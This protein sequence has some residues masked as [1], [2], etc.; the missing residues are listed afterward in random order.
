MYY[1]D[2]NPELLENGTSMDP[3]IVGFGL[4]M[5]VILLQNTLKMKKPSSLMSVRVEKYGIQQK[6]SIN[7]QSR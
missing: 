2:F 1:D 5:L 4:G 6:E 3:Y 7:E